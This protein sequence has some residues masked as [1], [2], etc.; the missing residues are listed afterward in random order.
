M[1]AFH[2]PFEDRAIIR[3][4]DYVTMRVASVTSTGQPIFETVAS[5]KDYRIT[6]PPLTPEQKNVL[7]TAA[8]WYQ[9]GAAHGGM[10][11]NYD[12]HRDAIRKMLESK[13]TPMQRLRANV[14]KACSEL[15]RAN[16]AGHAER[17]F[18]AFMTAARA[19]SDVNIA[20]K[21]PGITA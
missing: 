5:P 13:M 16:K 2:H 11:V 18:D 4:G 20:G 15:R 10:D 21:S 9:G 12:D 19:A 7:E 3:P 8:D 17:L 6:Q 1:T 14:D